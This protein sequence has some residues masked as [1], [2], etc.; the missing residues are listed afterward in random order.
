MASPKACLQ[1]HRVGRQELEPLVG[2]GDLL[3]GLDGRRSRRTDC[4]LQTWVTHSA[5]KREIESGYEKVAL[6][7][8][9][10]GEWTHVARQLPDG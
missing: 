5:A 6:Y 1:L 10:Q 2:T 3:A 9:D 4:L 7:A 8:D